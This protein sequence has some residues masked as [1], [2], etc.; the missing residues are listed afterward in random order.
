MPLSSPSLTTP[1]GYDKERPMPKG[2][3][4]TRFFSSLRLTVVLLILLAALSVL[5][6][7]IPQNAS[8]EQYAQLYSAKTY[9]VLRSLGLLDMYHSW[10]YVDLLVLL[11]INLAVCS[12]KRL[13]AVWREIKRGTKG[14]GRLGVFLTHLSVIVILIGGMIGA[15]WGFKGYVEIDEGEAV[16]EI[17][18]SSSERKIVP[19][20]FEVR[21]DE[22]RVSFYPDGTPKEY[23]SLLTFLEGGKAVM[24]RVPLRV[25]HPVTYKGLT[26]Y[27]ASYGERKSGTKV[28]LRIRTKGG[29][30]EDRFL[31]VR[32]VL[33]MG[34]GY[35]L[36]VMKYSPHIHGLGEG[37]L[38][39]VLPPQGKPKAQWLLATEGK[40]RWRVD[41]GMTITFLGAEKRY[42]TGLQVTRDPGVGVV[43]VGFGLMIVGLG[44]TFFPKK[45]R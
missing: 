9:K 4:I 33:K 41:E 27:Q 32:E 21:C 22:F 35:T 28:H 43:W 5:G 18:L 40:E 20:G 29:K 17:V 45:K 34:N 36:G 30:E 2:G 26:F 44:I 12:L 13:P 42:Y 25:N 37:A 16:S 3:A 15:L 7:V 31:G 23:L 38:V 39:A 11:A 6:T 19:L 8:I 1:G 10:W 14:W 24:E